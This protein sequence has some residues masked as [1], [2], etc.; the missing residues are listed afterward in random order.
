MVFTCFH[1]EMFSHAFRNML[2]PPGMVLDELSSDVYL[3]DFIKRNVKGFDEDHTV[4]CA[5]NGGGMKFTRSDL[6][7]KLF[8]C[9]NLSNLPCGQNPQ[10]TK[11]NRLL[12][13]L[14][15][16]FQNGLDLNMFCSV[17]RMIFIRLDTWLAPLKLSKPLPTTLLASCQEWPISFE[18]ASSWRIV[19]DRRAEDEV[20]GQS[21]VSAVLIGGKGLVFLAWWQTNENSNHSKKLLKS[22]EQFMKSDFVGL[23]W[24]T[25]STNWYKNWLFE[26]PTFCGKLN[27]GRWCQDHLRLRVESCIYCHCHRWHV[28]HLRWL[29]TCLE[30][31]CFTN[32]ICFIVLADRINNFCESSYSMF[33]RRIPTIPLSNVMKS[34][35]YVRYYCLVD[36]PELNPM[37]R[38]NPYLR[39]SP[40]KPLD[41]RQPGGGLLSLTPFV[42]KS[43]PLWSCST[44]LL[45][46]RCRRKG[47]GTCARS[48]DDW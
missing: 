6:A 15:I 24:Q 10:E 25:C 17:P 26:D 27:T 1:I 5:T 44:W 13:M 46:W 7:Q 48:L 34:S 42:A 37:R 36:H 41:L 16:G 43:G 11:E 39:P 8:F 18:L 21:D 28:W 32:V 3:A 29:S 38:K 14:C 45:F 2:G 9:L 35:P 12:A 23:S 20:S 19:F 4:V 31:K 22:H 33:K 30:V 40:L 47:Q